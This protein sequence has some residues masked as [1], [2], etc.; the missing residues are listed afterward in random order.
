[1]RKRRFKVPTLPCVMTSVGRSTCHS[2]LLIY[3]FPVKM[4]SVL[5]DPRSVL[6]VLSAEPEAVLTEH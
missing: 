2:D 1:M 5:A 4:V 3:L 6:L